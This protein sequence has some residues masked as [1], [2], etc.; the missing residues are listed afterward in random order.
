MA[1]ILQSRLKGNDVSNSNH[2]SL[3]GE[4]YGDI[5]AGKSP[6][7]IPNAVV[8]REKEA[9]AEG[10]LLEAAQLLMSASAPPSERVPEPE[11]NGVDAGVEVLFFER[12]EH[13][14]FELEDLAD[15]IGAGRLSV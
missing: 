12:F 13:R 1:K 9:M 2:L 5:G 11:M 14:I 8:E 4:G 7:V 10:Q 3:E 15:F 6:A